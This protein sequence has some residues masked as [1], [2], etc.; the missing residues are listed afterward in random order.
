MEYMYTNLASDRKTL[1]SYT[2]GK[3]FGMIKE[4]GITCSVYASLHAYSMV[5]MV[6]FPI[7]AE[8][9]IY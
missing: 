5:G 3:Y 6:I 7:I 1:T 9:M 8:D 2:A 4:P